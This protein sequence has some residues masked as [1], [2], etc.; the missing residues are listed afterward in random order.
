MPRLDELPKGNSVILLIYGAAGQ[1]KSD[2]LGTTGD[3]TV[4]FVA[5][6]RLGQW[7][8][9][10][11]KKRRGNW[12]PFTEIITEELQPFGGAK[13][14]DEL[15]KRVNYYFDNKLDEF[16]TICLDGATAF[17]R[18]AFNKGLDLSGAGASYAKS[19]AKSKT[20]MPDSLPLY[21]TDVRD[22]TNEMQLV[23]K[24]ILK[25]IDTCR[26]FGKHF[27]MT[28]HERVEFENKTKAD[29]MKLP[30]VHSIKP[31]F[32]GQTFPDEIPGIFDLVWHFETEGS[33]E[34]LKYY[35]RTAGD[36][37]GE[38]EGKGTMAKSSVGSGWKLKYYNP[39]FLDIVKKVRES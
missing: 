27:I 12:N 1:G 22:L 23:S 17:R 21:Q 32:T 36:S 16:D 39:N 7:K 6:G 28:A 5:E 33:G 4:V 8:T 10:D 11:F 26:S 38:T 15:T 3:R 29:M 13:A 24:F 2:F 9:D 20:G 37:H 34:S 31:G 18:F 30:V 14:L 19:I 35:A 25:L